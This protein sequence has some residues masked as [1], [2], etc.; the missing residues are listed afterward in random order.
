MQI[1]LSNTGGELQRWES[2]LEF[3]RDIQ[4]GLYTPADG[5]C[6]RF[7]EEFDPDAHVAQR[8]RDLAA[9]D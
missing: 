9:M 3:V 6:I 2:V 1:I 8:E 7:S 4:R 5:D